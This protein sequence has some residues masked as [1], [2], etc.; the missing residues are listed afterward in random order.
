MMEITLAMAVYGVGMWWAIRT[1]RVYEVGDLASQE[2]LA[3]ENTEL[4][5]SLTDQV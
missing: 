2:L 5:E 1:R 4:A 3:A